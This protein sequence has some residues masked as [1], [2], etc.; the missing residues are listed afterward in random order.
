MTAFGRNVLYRNNGDGRFE[1]VTSAARLASTAT[2]WGAG[3]TFIDIDR[4]GR[5]DLFVANYLAF[6]LASAPEPGAGANCQWSGLAVNCGPKGLPADTNLL[7]RNQGDGT[8]A[9]VSDALRHRPRHRPLLDDR[10]R[11]RPDRRRLD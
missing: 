3:C 10:G 2:R 11:R 8:F 5:L 9:D 6:D 4:D 1:D 7:Y